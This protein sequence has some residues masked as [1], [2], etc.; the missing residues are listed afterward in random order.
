MSGK[1]L[2]GITAAD[3]AICSI[4]GEKG[5]LR[6]RGY[7]I[8][9][10]AEASTF[11]EVVFL[12]FDGELPSR[13]GLAADTKRLARERAIPAALVDQLRAI[14][15]DA[16]PMA[17]LRTAVSLLGHHEPD[18]ES[19]D[20][21]VRRQ[22]SERLVAC[23]GTLVAALHRLSLGKEPLAPKP[24][25]GL[26]ANFL[27]LASGEVPSDAAARAIDVALILHAD[28]GFNAST[29]SARVTAATLS[30]VISAATSAIGTLKGP[31]HGGAN[32]KVIEMLLQ[33]D[34]EGIEPEAFVLRSLEQGEKI[35]GFG[36]R[37]YRTEDPRAT[38][39]RRMSKALADSTGD[40]KWFEMSQ[41]IED[42]MREAKGLNCNV[43]FYSASTYHQLGL[44]TRLFTPLFAV[45]RMAGWTAHVLEQLADNR[46]IR[47]RAK[48]VGPG[49]RPYVPTTDRS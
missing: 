32:E 31:L 23:T 34:E 4:D 3:S 43:D 16:H 14:P 22:I 24:E 28:H 17:S 41:Q 19:H 18:A 42:A 40:R 25:L 39:L 15:R 36:H 30:D 38:H 8:H 33:I 5:E 9:E 46:L 21:I 11:E 7:D 49:P 29:F 45:S 2:E 37:V 20:P 27:Y 44:P 26:A 48:Y 12:L 47:P 35:M 1:G 6:Y 13:A 10:L